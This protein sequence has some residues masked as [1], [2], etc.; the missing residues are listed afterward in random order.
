MRKVIKNLLFIS[1]CTLTLSSSAF[2]EQTP[3][4][5]GQQ[6]EDHFQERKAKIVAVM[7][8]TLQCVKAANS[9]EE[10]KQCMQQAKAQR[11]LLKPQRASAK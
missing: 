9:R 6:K 3:M 10:M 2:A 8:Q 7:E 11:A 4:G 1:V 5:A